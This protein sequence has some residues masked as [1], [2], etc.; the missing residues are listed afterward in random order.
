MSAPSKP[1]AN[2]PRASKPRPRDPGPTEARPQNPRKQA[3]PAWPAPVGLRA[4]TG[5]LLY[6]LLA[7]LPLGLAVPLKD[8]PVADEVASSLGLIAFA[9]A[10]LEFALSGRYRRVSGRIGVDRTLRV[11]RVVAYTMV[12]LIALH[13]FLYTNSGDDRR[14][15][16][17]PW[18]TGAEPSLGLA[19]LP[20]WT[21]TAAWLLVAALVVTAVD[22]TTLPCRYETWRRLHAAGAGLATALVAVHAFTD[23]GYSADLP[24]AVYWGALLAGAAASLGYGYLLQP[25]RQTAQPYVVDR[26]DP[27][28]ADSWE[29]RLRARDGLGL[30]FR[31]GQFAWLKLGGAFADAEHP[32]SI[33]TAPEAAPEV[34]FIIKEKGDFTDRIGTVPPGTPAYLDGPHGHFVPDSAPV[35]SVYIA[36]GTGIGPVLSHLRAFAV[37]GDRR[38]IVLIY[39]AQSPAALVCREE[40]AAL[41][42]TLDLTCHFVVREPD[43]DWT[44][45]VGAIDRDLLDACLPARGRKAQRYFVCG[46]PAMMAQTA[47]TLRRLGVPRGRIV[48]GS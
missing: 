14:F 42:R 4:P 26:V 39:A 5:A 13:P 48:T 46:P 6:A 10:L 27:V 33:S 40:L 22:R 2:K 21:G 17:A 18:F 32:F 8:R 30:A 11:H 9:I 23:G 20:L 7:L 36:A 44:G 41:S 47:R 19:P 25:W 35:P 1:R 3:A 12:V 45:R 28:A 15:A 24:L 43:G 37:H 29:L 16:T 38:A 31:P 34:G